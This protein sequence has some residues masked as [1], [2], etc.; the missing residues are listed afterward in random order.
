MVAYRRLYLS[1]LSLE[2]STMSDIQTLK[3][4]V[5]IVTGA[6]LGIGKATAIRLAKRGACVVVAEMNEKN[7]K[8]VVSQLNDDGY[9]ALFVHTD[10]S[11]SDDI[12]RLVEAT[13]KQYQHI[14]I[15]INNVG[16]MHFIEVD[17]LS[18]D[19]WNRL[20]SV[21]LTSMF[22]LTQACL[23]HL[24]QSRH[25]A[26]VNMSSV[27][28]SATIRELGA[29]PATKA[30][31]IGL[32]KSLAV[33]LAPH[34]R[35]NAIAPGVVRTE[36]WDDRDNTEALIADRLQYIPLERVGK[37]DDIAKGIAFLVSDDASFITGTVLTIDGG[38]TSRLYS[39]G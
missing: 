4:R 28:A 22:V 15:L 5:A 34:I 35:V 21:N 23:P 32:T 6:G 3:N 36:L 31:I 27:N 29:Y 25:A 39:G 24:R 37:P 33:E 17:T 20:L 13:I 38:M 12:Q 26:I 18:L 9:N 1:R 14:D 11:E 16:V 7:G 2:V 8:Q 30:G 10:V 19:E